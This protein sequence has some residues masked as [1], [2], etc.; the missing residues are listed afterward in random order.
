L[1]VKAL[2]K[3]RFETFTGA[4]EGGVEISRFKVLMNG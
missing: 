4:N 1:N 3:P 2:I